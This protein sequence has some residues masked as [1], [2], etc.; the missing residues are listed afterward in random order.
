MLRRQTGF[1]FIHAQQY[2]GFSPQGHLVCP[3]LNRISIVNA[4]YHPP[5]KKLPPP[6]LVGEGAILIS[7][8]VVKSLMAFLNWILVLLAFS[9]IGYG[10]YQNIAPYW[11]RFGTVKLMLQQSFCKWNIPNGYFGQPK[12]RLVRPKWLSHT[13]GL[14]GFEQNGTAGLQKEQPYQR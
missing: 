11:N 1:Y 12:R 8:P 10:N 2:H 6:Q 9:G 3:Q 7:A 4:F 5:N 13:L 14:P